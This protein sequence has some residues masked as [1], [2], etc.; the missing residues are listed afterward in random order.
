MLVKWRILWEIEWFAMVILD[1]QTIISL[2]IKETVRYFLI[3]FCVRK[4][5]WRISI[6]YTVIELC[7][8]KKYMKVMFLRFVKI[9]VII[10]YSFPIVWKSSHMRNCWIDEQCYQGWWKRFG[11]IYFA[12]ESRLKEIWVVYCQTT[13]ETPEWFFVFILDIDPAV[14]SSNQNKTALNSRRERLLSSKL[15]T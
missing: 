14:S 8:K 11:C 10:Y 1:A 3:F 12:F 2:R 4:W 6:W 13:R 15:T 5:S 7:A 9:A